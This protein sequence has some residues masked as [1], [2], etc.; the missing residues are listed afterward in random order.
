MDIIPHYPTINLGL[1]EIAAE[2]GTIKIEVDENKNPILYFV[3]ASENIQKY[4]LD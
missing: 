3:D 1:S 2:H 4:V